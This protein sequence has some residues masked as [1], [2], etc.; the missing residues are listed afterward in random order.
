M[1]NNPVMEIIDEKGVNG[2]TGGNEDR[3][4]PETVPKLGIPHQTHH[5]LSRKAS[6]QP[7]G[8]LPASLR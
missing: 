8:P 2:A 7:A 4:T 5:L 3:G 6:C 1:P